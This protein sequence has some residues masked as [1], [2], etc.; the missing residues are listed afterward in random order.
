MFR[1]IVGFFKTARQKISDFLFK[2]RYGTVMVLVGIIV[3]FWDLT[4]KFLLD[5]QQMPVIKGFFS[6]FSTHNTGGAWS[7]FSNMTWLLI[8]LSIVF[9]GAIAVANY[10][11]KTKN[12]FYAISMGILLSGAICNLYDR[13]ALGYVRDFIKLEFI[14]FPIFNIADIAICVGVTLLAVYFIFI[15]PKLEKKRQ[16]QTQ[17]ESSSHEQ[18]DEMQ[19]NPDVSLDNNIAQ[20]ENEPQESYIEQ[21]AIENLEQ[22][23]FEQDEQPQNIETENVYEEEHNSQNNI[24]VEE[25]KQEEVINT[26]AKTQK[27]SNAKNKT[28]AKNNSKKFNKTTSKKSQNEKR[29][30]QSKS[31]NGTLANEDALEQT[32]ENKMEEQTDAE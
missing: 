15:M 4:L 31:S 24:D 17:S 21:E 5:G 23:K 30:L 25:A 1:K 26:P 14:N 22:E 2:N 9:I 27:K 7:I 16:M 3:A 10:F 8:V 13:I 28:G 29:K 19:N 12:Y 6:F 18:T 32:T 11:L 20:D